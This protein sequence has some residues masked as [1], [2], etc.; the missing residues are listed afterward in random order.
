MAKPVSYTAPQNLGPVTAK[1]AEKDD[2]RALVCVF[3]A[4]GNDSHNMILPRAAN[5]GRPTYDS[6][7]GTLSV[8]LGTEL[9]L[10]A[11][12]GV[13][14]SMPGFKGI[15][16]QGKAA[17]LMNVG[18]LKEPTDRASYLA[19]RVRLPEQ[20]YS[21]NTQQ[22]LWRS[23]PPFAGLIL[24]GWMGRAHDFAGDAYNVSPFDGIPSTFSIAGRNT[25]MQ[26]FDSVSSDMSTSGPTVVV[27]TAGGISGAAP[28]TFTAALRAMRVYSEWGNALQDAMV[29]RIDDAVK[30]Q[31]ALAAQL[32]T[33]PTTPIAGQ[34]VSADG[35]F[36]PLSSNSLAQ[37]FKAV[38]RIIHSRNNYTQRRQLF[39]VT[40]GGWDHHD[41]LSSQYGPRLQLVDQAFKA[42]WDAMND[43]GMQNNVTV[44]TQSEFGRALKQNGDGSDHGWGGHALIFGG[45]VNGG[46]IYGTPP[47]LRNG[48]AND[49]GQG[50]MIPTTAVEQY[51][52]TLLEWWGIP[53]AQ[54]PVVLENL[55]RFKPT[56]LPMMSEP[57]P[58]VSVVPK[59][60]IPL[61]EGSVPPQLAVNIVDQGPRTYFDKDGRMRVVRVN[62][63]KNSRC[64]GGTIGAPNSLPTTW[65]RSTYTGLT[66]TIVGR[67]VDEDG[68]EYVDIRLHGTNPSPAMAL[69]HLIFTAG[70][71][72]PVL[73]GWRVLASVK[74]GIVG[75]TV[76]GINGGQPLFVLHY[77]NG[78]AYVSNSSGGRSRGLVTSPGYIVRSTFGGVPLSGVTKVRA[79][80]EFTVQGSATVDITVRVSRPSMEWV[81]A[82]NGD[83]EVLPPASM[84]TNGY[85]E[86]PRWNYDPVTR[87]FLGMFGVSNSHNRVHN[88][89][90]AGA[91][92]GTPGTWPAGTYGG[93]SGAAGLLTSIVGV[94]EEDGMPY[95]D[96]RLFGTPTATGEFAFVPMA[97]PAVSNV[98]GDVVSYV[99]LRT[100]RGKMSQLASATWETM[101][102]QSGTA[103]QSNVVSLMGATDDRL[104]TQKFVAALYMTTAGINEADCRI[105]LG[106]AAN[107]AIDLV[108]R[109][110]AM[111]MSNY[112]SPQ[113][114]VPTYG[115]PTSLAGRESFNVTGSDFSNA[116][117]AAGSS[118]SVRY[119]QE[120][121]STNV[122]RDTYPVV[123]SIAD[124]AGGNTDRMR[125]L[126][127]ALGDTGPA[128]DGLSSWKVE[129]GGAVQAE[130]VSQVT[131]RVPRLQTA[132][133]VAV[134]GPNNINIAQRG[135]K[136]NVDT[137]AAIPASMVQLQIGGND[138]FM[139]G[140]IYYQEIAMYDTRIS[141]DDAARLSS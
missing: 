59:L 12:W 122:S 97:T 70:G 77:L 2:Y 105:R 138:G 76:N 82:P 123:V 37:Q 87:R 54:L 21:H 95:M 39:Y 5:V 1:A 10:T 80:L 26:G 65:V 118:I 22:E 84:T 140:E 34:T 108:I 120:A 99:Y 91:G 139:A 134:F 25:Q 20:L 98:G 69:P 117:N 15:W 119:A 75:G 124:G 47:D 24:N 85:Y 106:V 110:G 141:D 17:V 57:E 135:Q 19:K 121:D 78:T 45:A 74:T 29:A 64:Q 14:P 58:V 125:M 55:P 136:A 18:Y 115:V 88:G 96:V 101:G 107:Q 31:A 28:G 130:P 83:T 132:T 33:L 129:V 41:S 89:T 30:S 60:R 102:R 42:F 32:Q 68:D 50:R 93:V 72:V 61:P 9:P 36:T 128:S 4:G 6:E 8:A 23:L 43:L 53:Q 79:V 35:R 48:S 63:I 92:V 40:L 49:A 116:Y 103:L 66:H 71:D 127:R 52:G 44:F 112:R 90:H 111:Q 113:P 86:P 131:A 73:P 94:G 100:V 3:L 7:R 46:Q 109:I 133:R 81:L 114:F 62:M 137:A 126:T 104:V 11:E 16:D 38:A 51:V 56:T 13:H 27:D 67:G